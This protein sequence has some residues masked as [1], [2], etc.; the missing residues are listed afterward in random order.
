MAPDLIR[1]GERQDAVL[2]IRQAH[3]VHADRDASDEWREVATDKLQVLNSSD[4]QRYLGSDGN[5]KAAI[6]GDRRAG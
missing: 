1:T 2:L 4:D 6:N 3:Y 5:G